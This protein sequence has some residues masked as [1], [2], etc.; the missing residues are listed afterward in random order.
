[1]RET[2]ENQVGESEYQRSA[3]EERLGQQRCLLVLDEDKMVNWIT[4]YKWA[5]A[6]EPPLYR[7]VD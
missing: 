2:S 3:K 4:S 6:L 5:V 1:M 7:H